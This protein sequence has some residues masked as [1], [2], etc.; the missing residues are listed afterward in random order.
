MICAK[1]NKYK[2]LLG[3]VNDELFPIIQLISHRRNVILA[4]LLLFLR[5]MFRRATIINTTSSDTQNS[6]KPYKIQTIDSPSFT[7]Y[8]I[9]KEE[10]QLKSLLHRNCHILE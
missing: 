3:I 5:Q 4:I 6:D 2:S 7:T 10:G 8:S 9:G 1:I